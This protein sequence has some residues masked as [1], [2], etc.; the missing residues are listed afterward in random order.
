MKN[1][2][3]KSIETVAYF[4]IENKSS[5]EIPL[6]WY[7]QIIQD[8]KDLSNEDFF[9]LYSNIIFGASY[10]KL[11][12]ADDFNQYGKLKKCSKIDYSSWITVIDGGICRID[13]DDNNYTY[14]ECISVS[15]M[16]KQLKIDNVNLKELKKYLR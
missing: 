7:D 4:N 12:K 14:K 2:I 6:K 1:K 3:I 9:R 8:Y 10:Y 16:E 5:C 11:F 15:P 13:W